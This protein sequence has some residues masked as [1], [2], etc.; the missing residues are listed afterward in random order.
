MKKILLTGSGGFII[1][2]FIRQ[3]IFNKLDYSFVSIDK[4][5]WKKTLDNIYTN[6][7]HK[8][9]I[10]DITNEHLIDIILEIEKP[11]IV[12][13]GADE[14]EYIARY[15]FVT[16]NIHATQILLEACN[17]WKTERFIYLST[18]KVYGSHENDQTQPWTELSP[19]KPI[20]TYAAS[21]ASAELLIKVSGINYNI[22]RLCNNYG[23]RQSVEKLIPIIVKKLAV[24]EQFK[25]D[26]EDYDFYGEN[27]VNLFNKGR[28]LR[29]WI[30]VQDTCSA[31]A[32]ILEKG[33][34][35]D[36]YNISAG[37]E[38][39]DTE[40]FQR[41][42]NILNT[43]HNQIKLVE[44][45]YKEKNYFRRAS[46]ANKLKSLGWTPEY[47]FKDGLAAAVQWAL[48]NKWHLR[49]E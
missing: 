49:E 4:I 5:K 12:I 48:D 6:K 2:N 19:I 37:H 40:I 1:C 27:I 47:K 18:D 35:N 31:I 24:N 28:N 14:S 43:G 11:D 30:Y 22:L 13:H 8:F 15:D 39:S 44:G 45:P 25:G 16:N 38:F 29:D 7:N 32:L 26:G 34:S 46:N 41:V 10:G 23:P 3:A 21:K 33:N 17:K 36:I 20:D 9:Y 42:C